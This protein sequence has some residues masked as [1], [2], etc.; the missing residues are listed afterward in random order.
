M[1]HAP[2]APAGRPDAN[3]E[4][5]AKV[6]FLSLPRAY[7]EGAGSVEAIETHMSWVFLTETHAYKLK[8]PQRVDHHD[9]HD[10][11]ARERHCRMEVR[12]NRRFGDDVYLGAVPLRVRP[13]GA[14]ALGGEGGTVDWLVWM[15]RLPRGRMLDEML[16]AG[17]A[18]PAHVAAFVK[19]LARFYAAASPEPMGGAELRAHLAA[20]IAGVV[21]ELATFAAHVPVP[22]VED[23]GERQVA[24]LEAHAEALDARVAAQR[25]V[26]GHGDLRPE[27]IC[28]ERPPRFIDCLEFSRELRIVDPA[29]EL[30]FLALE[31]ERLD[32]PWVRDVAFE[33]Y[34]QVT[35]DAPDAALVHFYQSCHACV[36][37]KLALRHLLDA[38]PR[39]PAR[40]PGA[41]RE[42]LALAAEH[43]QRAGLSR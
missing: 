6:A 24:F 40:W 33:T 42:Y 15:R 41:A 4:L 28:L 17:R 7:P 20:R 22:L 21:R 25:I 8:K 27:H 37:A 36:R 16:R 18:A 19:P 43:L 10:V 11:A 5:A 23:L 1:E 29:E 30:G 35:G 12:L 2:R 32:A 14:L 34:T 26:E 31:C 13:G 39:E 38:V 9:L 3:A